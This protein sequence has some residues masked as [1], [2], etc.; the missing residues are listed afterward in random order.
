MWPQRS[1]RACGNWRKRRAVDFIAIRQEFAAAD[2]SLLKQLNQL[3]AEMPIVKLL[4]IPVPV[5]VTWVDVDLSQIDFIQYA[6]IRVLPMLYTGS[7][8]IHESCNDPSPVIDL[9]T[10]DYYLGRL[11]SDST[12]GR[13][14]SL[15]RLMAY[16]GY[17]HSAAETFDKGYWEPQYAI[18]PVTPN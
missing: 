4:D 1:K 15:I 8:Y 16:V 9:F 14:K 6:E 18:A 10:S 7:G 12:A 13:Y 2:A 11:Y 3:K 5:A 17:L